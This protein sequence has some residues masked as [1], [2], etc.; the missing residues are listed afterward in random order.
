MSMMSPEY[1]L[2]LENG[3]KHLVS[4]KKNVFKSKELFYLST[5]MSNFDKPIRT[6]MSNNPHSTFWLVDEPRLIDRKMISYLDILI[7]YKPLVSNK[8][9]SREMTVLCPPSLKTY[10]IGLEYDIPCID[11]YKFQKNITLQLHYRSRN[12]LKQNSGKV[13]EKNFDLIDSQDED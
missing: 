8:N 6:L 11:F 3:L 10:H 2:Y 1:D 4:A 12:K 13:S 5:K 9:Y 7:D